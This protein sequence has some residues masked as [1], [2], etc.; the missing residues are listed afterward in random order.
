MNTLAGAAVSEMT[1]CLSDELFSRLVVLRRWFHQHPELA[2]EEADTA[3]RIINEL[4]RLNIA[5]DYAGVGHAVIGH[6]EGLDATRPVIGLRAEMDALPGDE[7]TGVAYASVHPG[8]MH[9]CG[10]GAHMAM[11]IGAAELLC[12]DLPPGPVRLIFQPAEES[13]GGARTAIADGALRNVAAIFAGHVTHEYHTGQIMVR[14]GVVTAQSD[15]FSIHIRGRGGHGARPHEA[16]DAVVISGFLI[17]ALQTLVSRETNP[18]HPTVVTIGKIHAG[19]APNVIAEEAT[20]EGSIRT[21]RPEVRQHILHGIERMIRAAAELHN[22]KINVDFSAGYPPVVNDPVGAA[23]ARAA[24]SR[25]VGADNVV[26]S[27]YPSMGSEDFSFYLNHVPGAFVRFGAREESWEPVPLHSP[28]FDIDEKAL[29]V[30]A[31]FYDQVARTA[32]E[33]IGA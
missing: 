1:Q 22:A 10:H 15:R 9:A 21:S 20:L 16:V 24:A 23:I 8:K 18:F 19:S 17:T 11:V 2:F 33:S 27:E 32:Q 28:A 14:D 4:E 25:V 5:C 13:G 12:N 6:I 26:G 30:G 7:T 3:Q 31:R 29:A